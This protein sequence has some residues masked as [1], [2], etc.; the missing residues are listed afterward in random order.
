MQRFKKFIISFKKLIVL[1]NKMPKKIYD[2]KPPK[3]KRQVEE[4]IKDFLSSGKS[5]GVKH[6]SK[7]NTGRHKKKAKFLWAK[8]SFGIGLILAILM[9]YLFF[10]LPKASIEMW[11]KIDVLSFKQTIFADKSVD[12]VDLENLVMPAQYLE[13]ERSDNQDFAAT[14]NAFN[15]GKSIGTI[16]VYNKYDSLVPITL[17]SGTHFMSNS[18]K[19]FTIL[20]KIVIPA[21]KKIGGKIIPGSINAAVEAVEGGDSYNIGPSKFVVPKLAGGAYYYSVYAESKDSMTGGFAGRIKKVT[22]DDIQQAKDTLTKKLISEAEF[23]LRNKISADYILLDNTI[24]S[25]VI[26]ALSGAKA[27]T[28]ADNFTYQAK[29]KVVALV[30]RRSD[31]EKFAKNYIFSQMPNSNIMIDKS[32]KI[33]Q[34]ASTADIKKGKATVILDFSAGTYQAIDRNIL[35][36]KIRNKT[37]SEINQIINDNLGEKILKVKVKLWPFWVTKSPNNQKMIQVDLKLE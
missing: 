16:M 25:E 4:K 14:G 34:S 30:L 33:E 3:L 17:K 13:E 22:D 21:G 27:D 9:V 1:Q 35:A 24:S 28:V 2:I 5:H 8:I 29:V 15:E 26:D 31:L 10:K 12:V 36:S 32:F 6:L 19:Y 7:K 20:Q 37:S 23:S 11:P 18:G